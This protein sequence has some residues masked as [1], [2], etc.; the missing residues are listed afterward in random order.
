MK[1]AIIIT[2]LFLC[3]FFSSV[4]ASNKEVCINDVC[5]QAEIADSDASRAKGLMFRN[6]L[7]EKAGMLF[8]LGQG[9]NDFWMKNMRFPLDLIW[10]DGKKKIIDIKENLLP[11][12]GDD[13]PLFGPAQGQSEYVLEVNSG[14]A[15]ENEVK[16]GDTVTF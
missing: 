15:K 4:S 14:F 13:C 12:E 3:A 11:C 16:V 2:L 6:S 7:G 5:V 10:I 9:G 8:I 1:I